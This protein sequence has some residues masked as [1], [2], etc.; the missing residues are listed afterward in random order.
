MSLTGSVLN[1]NQLNFI[2]S[3]IMNLEEKTVKMSEICL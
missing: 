1:F 3:V 2:N